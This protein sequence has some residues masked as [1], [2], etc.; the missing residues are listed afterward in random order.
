MIFALVCVFNVYWNSLGGVSEDLFGAT[1]GKH[2]DRMRECINQGADVNF[3]FMG[4]TTSLQE[5][6]DDN[7]AKAAAILLS[8]GASVQLMDGHFQRLLMAPQFQKALAKEHFYFR[9]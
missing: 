6:V 4:T 1:I 5:A 9:D 7:D 3:K 2:Y 8:H